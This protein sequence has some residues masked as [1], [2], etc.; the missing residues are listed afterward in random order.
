MFVAN[1]VELSTKRAMAVYNDLLLEGIDK[2]RISFQGFGN[3][4]PISPELDEETRQLN[5]RVDVVFSDLK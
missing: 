1:D 3:S 5:R 4:L 2:S